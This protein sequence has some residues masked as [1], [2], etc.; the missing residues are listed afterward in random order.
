[1]PSNPHLD[2]ELYR[3]VGEEVAR[4][5]FHPGAM[6]RAVAEANGNNDLIQALYIKS[7]HAELLRQ[8]ELQDAA[9]MPW[10]QP[11]VVGAWLLP[12]SWIA[13]LSG[14]FAIPAF[15][16]Y[17]F[18]GEI[19]VF[20]GSLVSIFL[21]ILGLHWNGKTRTGFYCPHCGAVYYWSRC[22]AHEFPTG[23]K[24]SCRRCKRLYRISS[25]V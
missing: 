15:V 2:D 16:A 21:V 22:N 6:A 3:L 12:A 4:K 24:V 1:M 23:K 11:T 25:R 17:S 20:G 9:E 13:F 14:L 7:R 8:I 10:G 5:E 19:G 18:V